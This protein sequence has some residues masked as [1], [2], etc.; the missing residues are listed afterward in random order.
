MTKSRHLISEIQ[1]IRSQYV[2][3]VGE[4]RRRAWPKAIRGR[5]LELVDL[6][7]LKL[8]DIAN[9]AGVPYET[10]CQWK[11]QRAKQMG[12]GNFHQLPVV[13]TQ[14]LK[15]AITNAA[16]VTATNFKLA[17]LTIQTPDGFMVHGLDASSV[18]LILSGLRG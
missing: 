3:E 7:E 16:T 9:T 11:H 5:V 4:G 13:Q 18:V 14:R 8:R 10:V 15:P 12:G 2:A 1:S 17:G 6:G